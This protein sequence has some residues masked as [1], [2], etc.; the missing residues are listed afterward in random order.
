MTSTCIFG[1]S[2]KTMETNK[3]P[4]CKTYSR[5]KIWHDV[6][7]YLKDSHSLSQYSPIL[8]NQF[9]LPGRADAT[10]KLWESKGLK[11]IQDLYLTNSDIMGHYRVVVIHHFLFVADACFKFELRQVNYLSSIFYLKIQFA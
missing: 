1:H 4:N 3:K 8:G 5:L 2:K 10:F 9:F 11:M 6:Q 7:T